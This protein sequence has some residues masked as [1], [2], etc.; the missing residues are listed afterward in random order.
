MKNFATEKPLIL[1]TG[2]SGFVGRALCRSLLDAGHRVRGVVRHERALPAGAEISI[3]GDIGPDTKWQTALADVNC[4]IHLAAR[5]HVMRE[6]AD[7]PHQAFHL[8]N[9]AGTENLARQ[10]A[11]AGVKRLVYV[12][13][14]K[15][16]GERTGNRPFC[17]A[18][19]A[20]PQDPYAQSK[21]AAEQAL[22]RSAHET[23]LESVIMRPPLVYGPGVGGNFLRLI[24]LIRAGVPLPFGSIQNQRSL[25]YLGNLV[26]ALS[27]CSR[28][29]AAAGQ[30]FLISDGEDLS[31][32]ELIRRLA[33]ALG[34]PVMQPPFPTSILKLGGKIIGKE[35]EM[36][37]LLESLQ[38]DSSLIRRQLGWT[39]RYTVE[40]GLAAMTSSLRSDVK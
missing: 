9:T 5:V 38:V 37:R 2:A 15:V 22:H 23:G 34:K 3:T 17:A 28:H 16:N 4:I 8:V 31:T 20:A 11:A 10:A 30:T 19:A 27:L 12:S 32:P 39:P 36:A 33:A 18:D 24:K 35:E 21:W 40:Q 14:I 13:T 25:V 6:T 29:P 1:V 7:D 26:D